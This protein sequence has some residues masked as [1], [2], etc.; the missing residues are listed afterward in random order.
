MIFA[1]KTRKEFSRLG[2]VERNQVFLGCA[3]PNIFGG[4]Q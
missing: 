3:E 4:R 1:P 2:Y